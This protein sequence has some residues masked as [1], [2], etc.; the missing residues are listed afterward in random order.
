MSTKIAL[1]T[2]DIERGNDDARFLGWGYL[3][4]RANEDA[5]QVT[6]ADAFVLARAAERGWDAEDL[7][8]WSNS[9]DGRWFADWF[10]GS[11]PRRVEYPWVGDLFP[12]VP[13]R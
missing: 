9:K 3:G 8:A 7:F 12:K 10:F 1:T 6:E 4:A 5:A 13:A 2:A 11:G